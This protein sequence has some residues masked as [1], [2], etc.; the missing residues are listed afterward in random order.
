FDLVARVAGIAGGEYIHEPPCCA[1]VAQYG[2]R[3]LTVDIQIAVGPESQGGRFGQAAARCEHI[4]E[5]PGSRVVPENLVCAIAADVKVPVRAD[6]QSAWRLQ[7][8]RSRGNEFTK[9]LAAAGIEA[10][11]I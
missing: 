10:Q 1:V 3:S 8:A 2:I 9:K 11:H 5:G 6:T 4:D 7:S